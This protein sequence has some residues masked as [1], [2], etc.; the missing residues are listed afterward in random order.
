VEERK[1]RELREAEERLSKVI[2]HLSSHNESTYEIRE[3][4]I[5]QKFDAFSTQSDKRISHLRKD[6]FDLLLQS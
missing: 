6:L 4:I 3:E 2:N 1:I 5:I